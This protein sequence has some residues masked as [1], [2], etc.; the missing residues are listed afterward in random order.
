MYSNFRTRVSSIPVIDHH[1]HNLLCSPHQST[2][3]YPF[4][5]VFSEANGSALSSA[6]STLVARRICKELSKLLSCEP[7][8]DAIKIARE[9]L[10]P[11]KLC[12]L[13]FS[14]ANI[15]GMLLD[16]G[17]EG[18][19]QS[20]EEHDKYCSAKTKRIMRIEMVA[21]N[22][23][24]Q[25]AKHDFLAPDDLL[26]D[27]QRQL[28]EALVSDGENVVGFKSIAAYRTGL[29]I[30]A[31]S[32]TLV[33][34]ALSAAVQA[35]KL[36]PSGRLRLSSKPLVDFAVIIAL[37]IAVEKDLVVQFHTGF[38]DRD[39]DLIEANPLLL[40][41]ILDD[42][43][44]GKAKIVCLHVYPYAREA[45]YLASVYPNVYVD[46]GLSI[47]LTSHFGQRQILR[48][49]MELAP[50]C[51][52]LFSSDGHYHP[53]SFYF[54]A[55]WSRG[56]L[57]DVL[58]ESISSG[59]LTESEAFDVAQDILFNNANRLYNL[60]WHANVVPPNPPQFLSEEMKLQL[61][62]KGVEHIRL[63]WVDTSNI[64]RCRIIP[65]EKFFSK[66][67]QRGVGITDGLM[68]LTAISD[69]VFAGSAVGEIQYVPDLGSLRQLPY[70]PAHA[71]AIGD[72]LNRS[73]V[74]YER[75]PRD[76][77]KR[78][79]AKL[80]NAHGLSLKTG[81]ETE[82]ILYT[83]ENDELKPLDYT[84][85]SEVAS[86]RGKSG[87]IVDRIVNALQQQGIAVEQFHSESASG[88]FEIATKYDECLK[89]VDE[90]VFTRQT[91]YA[92]AENNGVKA[93]LLPKLS[94][95]QAGSASHVHLSIWKSELNVFPSKI[96]SHGISTLGKSFMA[97]ILK[98]L[99]ALM[100]ITMPS[101]NSY[102]RVLPKSW[103]GI[104]SIWGIENREAPL[105]VVS[106]GG[107]ISN[108]EIK[109]MDG[110]ANPYLALGAIVAAGLDGIENSLHLP[111]PVQVDPSDLSDAE[112]VSLG[113]RALP[114]TLHDALYALEQDKYIQ[115]ALG[116]MLSNGFITV[117]KKELELMEAKQPE[118][119]L[120]IY[121]S[122]Y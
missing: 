31:P 87:A 118:E 92:V 106:P 19:N 61:I 115:S 11:Q 78:M 83:I 110:T 23:I 1:A 53:E 58:I 88:Q 10:G 41:S 74:P 16:D 109:S 75:C 85:Y 63:M 93:T 27:F 18:D 29:R 77:L 70:H 97:G 91:I 116:E 67:H 38:G 69:T 122:R 57:S 15:H 111:E 2:S 119:Q 26:F 48:E 49:L 8:L 66:V 42:P 30:S 13:Y 7:D 35:C 120:K 54:G 50:I 99:P 45:A 94:P 89:A 36:T 86:M 108:L 3:S 101:V 114:N 51:K 71:A 95:L 59:E 33:S 113:I 43:E 79:L 96:D 104:Y 4:E 107:Q 62:R 28:A 20:I 73:G 60:G 6:G 80:R 47:P 5:C 39:L 32:K 9:E 105:R 76:F 17:L 121:Y 72:M 68:G 46:F 90:L 98:H 81:F 102:K 44:L 34:E 14:I 56:A 40:R 12:D 112:M 100:A 22:V 65:I 84:V 117:R 21:E 24:A 37:K 82:F 64:A 25:L 52:I 55:V 103:C